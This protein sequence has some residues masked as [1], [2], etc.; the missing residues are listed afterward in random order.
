MVETL[1]NWGLTGPSL[2]ASVIAVSNDTVKVAVDVDGG[3]EESKAKWFPYSTVYSS[4][5]GQAGIVCQKR[6]IM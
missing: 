6:E 4:R 1:Y 2:N 3:Q 5:M